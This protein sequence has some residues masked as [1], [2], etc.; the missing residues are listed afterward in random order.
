MKK[1]LSLL[2]QNFI[3][4]LL[5]WN[6]DG[7]LYGSTALLHCLDKQWEAPGAFNRKIRSKNYAS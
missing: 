6:K 7:C 5:K 2:K 1:L 4:H 3:D